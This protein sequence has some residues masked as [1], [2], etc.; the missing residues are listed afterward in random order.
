MSEVGVSAHAPKAEVMTLHEWT[1][2]L[3]SPQ[4]KQLLGAWPQLRISRRRG[5]LTIFLDDCAHRVSTG[6]GSTLEGVWRE[7]SVDLWR[8]LEECACGKGLSL[9][10]SLIPIH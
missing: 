4:I 2:R 7:V 9:L 8:P 3:G 10:F 5:S 1:P 6:V